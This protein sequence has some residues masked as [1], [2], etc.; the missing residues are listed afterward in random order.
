MLFFPFL[1][2]LVTTIY[3]NIRK[4]NQQKNEIY[5]SL[6]HDFDPFIPF[7]SNFTSDLNFTSDSNFTSEFIQDLNEEKERKYKINAEILKIRLFFI[8]KKFLSYLE[9]PHVSTVSKTTLIK[10]YD[11]KNTISNQKMQNGGLFKDFDF[12]KI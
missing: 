5:Y 7:H 11:K 10:K 1:Y 9:N 12:D 8:K 3:S 6:N 2:T 4:K